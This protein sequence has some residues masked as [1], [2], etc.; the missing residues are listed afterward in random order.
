MAVAGWR[1]G[2]GR[3]EAWCWG[4]QVRYVAAR[5]WHSHE[6]RLNASLDVDSGHVGNERRARIANLKCRIGMGVEIGVLTIVLS[7][8]ELMLIAG[9]VQLTL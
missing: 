8:M 1:V 7:A 2:E 5:R 4:G 9:V 6:E 3:L